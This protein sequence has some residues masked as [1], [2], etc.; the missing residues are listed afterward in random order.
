M[1]DIQIPTLELPVIPAKEITFKFN[2]L[3]K[4][5]TKLEQLCNAAELFAKQEFEDYDA[6]LL[7]N[8]TGIKEFQVKLK[9]QAS[10]L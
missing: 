9:H 6:L 3:S 8:Q 2:T 4:G 1:S 10:L 5:L 7:A